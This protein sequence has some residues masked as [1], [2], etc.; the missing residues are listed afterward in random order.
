MR[1]RTIAL[2][3]ALVFTSA[4]CQRAVPTAPEQY[5]A[6]QQGD[7]DDAFAEAKQQGKPVLLYWGAEWCP[8]CA[9]MKATLFKDPGFVAETRNFI[10]VYLDGDTRG[11]QRWGERFGISGYPTVIVLRP[12]ANRVLRLTPEDKAGVARAVEAVI[13]ALGQTP[14]SYYQH[15]RKGVAALGN[16]VRD[17]SKAHGG[18]D[19]VSSL[20]AKMAV[21]CAKQGPQAAACSNWAK[22]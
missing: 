3:L 7:V 12:G 2:A 5:I 9:Q 19:V 17:W 15:T 11:A 22:G 20:Q 10:P 14:D 1:L 4:G 6:W 13:T 8:P 21:A 18:S 16:K